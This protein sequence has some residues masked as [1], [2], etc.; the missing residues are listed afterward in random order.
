M[1]FLYQVI[2]HFMKYDFMILVQV[3]GALSLFVVEQFKNVQKV[4]KVLPILF[5]HL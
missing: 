4:Q 5:L 1:E 3:R 2:T